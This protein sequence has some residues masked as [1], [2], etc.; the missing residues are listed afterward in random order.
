[1]RL[2]EYKKHKDIVMYKIEDGD[3]PS[4][5]NIFCACGCGEEVYMNYQ[6]REKLINDGSAFAVFSLGH[7]MSWE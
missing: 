7:K 3:K 6:S 4:N 1:M 5:I 2:K